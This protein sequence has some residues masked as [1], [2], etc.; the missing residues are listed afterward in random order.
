VPT[1]NDW[2]AIYIRPILTALRDLGRSSAYAALIY[3]QSKNS[4]KTTPPN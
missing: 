3:S 2:N 4:R 1:L